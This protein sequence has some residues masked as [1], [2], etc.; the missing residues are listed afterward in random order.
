MPRKGSVVIISESN[1]QEIN[2]N[3]QLVKAIA[4]SHYWNKL[5]LSGQAKNCVDIKRMENFKDA[6]YITEVVNLRFL[7]PD[8]IER[9][10]NGRQPRDLTIQ[11]LFNVKTLDWQEQQQLLNF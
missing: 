3:P 4:R 5:L 1:K 9:I 7:A 11:K 2:I 10:L 8:I 6:S